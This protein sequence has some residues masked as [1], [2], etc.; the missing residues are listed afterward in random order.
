MIIWT[1][2]FLI[3]INYS[4]Q[5]RKVPVQIYSLGIASTHEPVLQLTRLKKKK[6]SEENNQLFIIIVTIYLR[7]S[8]MVFKIIY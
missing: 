3:N 2:F 6:K 4:V 5:V 1:T 8:L 7:S